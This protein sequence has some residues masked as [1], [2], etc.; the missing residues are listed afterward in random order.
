MNVSLRVGFHELEREHERGRERGRGR[1][2][3]R[4]IRVARDEGEYSGKG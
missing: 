3:E 2:H 4:C 1:G